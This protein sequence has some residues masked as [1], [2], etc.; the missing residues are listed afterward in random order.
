MKGLSPGNTTGGSGV[1][2][3]AAKWNTI[4]VTCDHFLKHKKSSDKKHNIPPFCSCGLT[5]VSVCPDIQTA[6]FTPDVFS[7]NILG[8]SSLEPRSCIDHRGHLKTLC[9]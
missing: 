3:V 5:Q 2:S 9:T 8:Y 6:S 7:V 4:E 1:N